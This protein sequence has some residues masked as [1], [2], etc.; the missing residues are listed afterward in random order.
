MAKSRKQLNADYNVKKKKFES[1][2]K[3]RTEVPCQSKTA[4]AIRKRRS[5]MKLADPYSAT[6]DSDGFQVFR[7]KWRCVKNICK[8]LRKV[9]NEYK[10]SK[11]HKLR[12]DPDKLSL[13]IDIFHD[14]VKNTAIKVTK[15]LGLKGNITEKNIVCIVTYQDAKQQQPHV[16]THDTRAFSVLH[17]MTDRTIW[18]GSKQYGLKARDVLVMKGGLCHAGA[19]HTME[20]PTMM[21]HV[22]VGYDTKFTFVCKIPHRITPSNSTTKSVAMAPCALVIIY[23]QHQQNMNISA[24]YIKPRIENKAAAKRRQ[25]GGGL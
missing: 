23:N 15:S 19:E 6:L 22:P 2:R 13:P 10:G 7:K 16:D 21:L 12:R 1:P 14:S 17:M 4:S 20:R 25:S 24:I 9:R 5:R 11:D 8:Y 3:T 18:V